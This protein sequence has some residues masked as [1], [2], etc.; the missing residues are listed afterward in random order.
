MAASFANEFVV[1]AVGTSAGGLNALSELLSHLP[2]PAH[3][4]LAV[5]IVQHLDPH[6]ASLLVEL[7][8]RV[9]ALPVEWAADGTKLKAGRVYVGPPGP[10]LTVVDGRLR[11][12][13]RE[14]RFPDGIDGFFRSVAAAYRHRCI[15]VILSGSGG[16]GALGAR[17]IKGVGGIV[18]AQEPEQAPF[19]S[20][21]RAAIESGCID[22]V[23]PVS[24]IA[25]ELGRLA[26]TSRSVWRRIEQPE[27][28]A[29]AEESRHVAMILRL[30]AAQTGV[31]FSGYKPSTVRRRLARCMMMAKTATAA[32]YLAF[33]HRNR[34]EIARLHESMLINVTEFFRDPEYFEY[35]R[36]RILPEI[37]RRHV[38]GS[39]VRIWVPG[40][41]TGE[42]AY[43]YGILMRELIEE[44][45]QSVPVQIFGTDISQPAIA[46]AQAGIYSAADLASLG[47][48][49][50]QRHFLQREGGFQIQKPVRELCIFARQNV[51]R[52]SPFS[53]LDLLSC[54]NLLIYLNA[55]Y[56]RKLMPIF[57]YALRADG[58]LVLGHS[59]SIG[60]TDLF[61]ALDSRFR[62][63]TPRLTSRRTTISFSAGQPPTFAD[64]KSAQS[65]APNMPDRPRSSFDVI[66]EAD[67]IVANRH[68]PP[69]LVVN[70]EMD[71]VQFR[72]EVMPYLAPVA[73]RAS[74]KLA[75]M[76]REGLG[77]ELQILIQ[78]ARR[79]NIRVKKTGLSFMQGL[80][81]REIAI[82]VTPFQG[83]LQ[84]ERFFLLEFAGHEA[85]APVEQR[86]AAGNQNAYV[87]QIEQLRQD[88]QAAHHYLHSTIEKH[89]AT[90]QELRAANEEVQSSNE[91]LQSTNEELET[92]KEELQSTNEEL[93][94]VN[95]ELHHR[96]LELVQVNNDLT[97]LIHSVHLPILILGADLRIRRFT[98]PAEKLFNL[99][100]SD[101]GRPLSDINTSLEVKDLAR[102]VTETID[103][104][105]VSESEVQD[106]QGRWYSLR[107]RP[108]RTTENKI[109]GVVLTLFDIDDLKR[110]MALIS[111]SREFELAVFETTREPLVA[112]DAELRIKMANHAF[113]RL[114]GL[115]REFPEGRLFLD[116]ANDHGEF[117]EFKNAL[118]DILPSRSNL[119]DYE[120]SVVLPD[121]GVVRL[122]VTGR[123]VVGAKTYPCILLSLLRIP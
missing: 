19:A 3:G 57:H 59:E 30:L 78:E 73:G 121:A 101:S 11:L 33:L 24:A 49:R 15:G 46:H 75:D 29:A 103:T 58:V 110:T 17:A 72:G 23:L 116:V 102:R 113:Y 105:A 28:G 54:R 65:A 91:E 31:D 16:D 21:P 87:G 44:L 41:S 69:G 61:R 56:Q 6:H 67:R 63:Y 62:I 42:E 14:K 86:P 37:L 88:L 111:E 85:V 39:P 117:V 108:Y 1:V 90:N 76:A 25:A 52:D 13:D 51:V 74:L 107:M 79:Q 5:V 89:E 109:E 27:D 34:E 92:A 48:E 45:G 95:E 53:R 18:F 2:P 4:G 40:C 70:D 77:L 115:E 32:E 26:E 50:I 20:M 122:L 114:F 12:V 66:R 22:G 38:D 123:Q 8:N 10:S 36:T 94:T 43:T 118:A 104:L 80:E 112:L 60:Q 93:S 71:I 64:F 81:A 47:A 35:L 96:Q 9:S 97:N 119:T 98:P 120:L 84:H 99:I 106:R 100:P 83:P 7:L 68:G 82:D 55:E